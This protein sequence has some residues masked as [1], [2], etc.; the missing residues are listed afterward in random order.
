MHGIPESPPERGA[1]E[2]AQQPH[3]SCCQRPPRPPELNLLCVIHLPTHN[4]NEM[5][6]S[7]APTPKHTHTHIKIIITNISIS[8]V[9]M[10]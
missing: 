10:Y 9:C 7:L 8:D 6:H 5:F 3:K 4:N 1:V 2:E